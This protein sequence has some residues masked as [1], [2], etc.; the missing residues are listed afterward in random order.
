M[1]SKNANSTQTLD[2]TIQ[3]N[4]VCNFSTVLN[5]K[6]TG[7]DF[8]SN[9]SATALDLQNLKVEDISGLALLLAWNRCANKNNTPL[10]FI[11]VPLPLQDMIDLVGLKSILKIN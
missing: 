7:C 11:N 1:S 3:I 8:I 2:N 5:F 6:K 9:H 10:S 4:G